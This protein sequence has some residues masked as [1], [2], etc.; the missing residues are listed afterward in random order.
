MHRRLV[1]VLLV[2]IVLSMSSYAVLAA[3]DG[4]PHAKEITTTLYDVDG[5]NVGEILFVHTES[6]NLEVTVTVTDLPRGYYTLA[7]FD[8]DRCDSSDSQPFASLGDPLPVVDASISDPFGGLLPFYVM[9]SG[10]G[11]ITYT[12]DRVSLGMMLGNH[13]DG[14]AVVVQA[15]PAASDAPATT[16]AQQ[17]ALTSATAPQGARVACGVVGAD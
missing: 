17:T 13:G 9:L 16:S 1:L 12:T 8:S 3:P 11:N 15:M 14:S 2:A 5:N 10:Q 6:G 4:K 7:I